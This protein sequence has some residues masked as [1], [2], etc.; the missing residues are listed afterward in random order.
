[1]NNDSPKIELFIGIND[2]LFFLIGILLILF[3]A[4]MMNNFKHILILF[5]SMPFSLILLLIL[6][7]FNTQKRI[8]YVSNHIDKNEYIVKIKEQIGIYDYTCWSVAF[9]FVLLSQTS[10][11]LTIIA[12]IFYFL[13]MINVSKSEYRVFVITS[14]KLFYI[15]DDNKKIAQFVSVRYIHASCYG[16]LNYLDIT[17]IKYYFWGYRIKAKKSYKNGLFYEKYPINKEDFK[18][19]KEFWIKLT[20]YNDKIANNNI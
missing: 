3:F 15:T 8:N 16:E 13:I 18:L 5:I 2:I 19:I 4:S 1:M 20:D 17:D 7:K 11:I 12:F 6:N 10:I 9:F 14:K